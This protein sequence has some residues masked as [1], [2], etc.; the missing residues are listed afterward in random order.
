[1]QRASVFRP[2]DT[3]VL[4][5]YVKVVLASAALAAY[6]FYGIAALWLGGIAGTLLFARQRGGVSRN[7][8]EMLGDRIEEATAKRWNAF[9]AEQGRK[10]I[11]VSARPPRALRAV[12]GLVPG[13]T[14]MYLMGMEGTQGPLPLRL[15]A[16]TLS[17]AMLFLAAVGTA[18]RTKLV[19]GADGVHIEGRA[20]VRAQGVERCV[21]TM[22]ELGVELRGEAQLP[23]TIS[24]ASRETAQRLQ[25]LLV[26][27]LDRACATKPPETRPVEAVGFR[28]AAPQVPWAEQLQQAT[29]KEVRQGILLRVEPDEL[30]KLRVL[31]EE[32]ANPDM[33][34]AIRAHVENQRKADR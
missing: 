12:S 29:S 23:V 33:A 9:A 17:I 30:P 20:F 8:I 26:L 32:T 7:F 3:A 6:P 5:R 19:L 1:V 18:R 22:D 24:V 16:V 25:R 15:V 11:A 31:L 13:V 10:C 14:M 28:E 2:I 4:E 34:E 21:T 27:S